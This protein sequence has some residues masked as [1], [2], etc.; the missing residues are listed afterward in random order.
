MKRILPYVVCGMA[1]FVRPPIRISRPQAHYFELPPDVAAD[2]IFSKRASIGAVAIGHLIIWLGFAGSTIFL[3]QTTSPILWTA[4]LHK[5]NMMRIRSMEAEK[6]KDGI[7][8]AIIA[9][10]LS[11]D[12]KD[13]ELKKLPPTKAVYLKR[14][15][16]ERERD[17][18]F[19][20]WRQVNHG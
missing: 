1:I 13:K 15:E 14:K 4:L 2:W 17:A 6:R 11:N 12:K 19:R 5:V 8:K 7:S 20:Q 16:L 9:A 10:L 3:I 18:L